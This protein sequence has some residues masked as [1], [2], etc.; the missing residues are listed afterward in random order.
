MKLQRIRDIT[1]VGLGGEHL[2]LRAQA[3]RVHE[4]GALVLVQS[5]VVLRSLPEVPGE[6]SRFVDIMSAGQG[7]WLSGPTRLLAVTESASLVRFD[8][9]VDPAAGFEVL[10]HASAR[11]DALCDIRAREETLGRV[12]RLLE[13]LADEHGRCPPIMQRDIAALLW[14][15]HE[16]VCRAIA[17]LRR[18]RRVQ[19]SADGATLQ[20][21]S[22]TRAA[23]AAR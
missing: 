21:K 3:G 16:S 10:A 13:L 19:W 20:G 9:V 8:A 22:A 12:H 15:R 14:T 18:L 5:G 11:V 6:R 7:A 23:A 2:T 1:A 17:G 4:G